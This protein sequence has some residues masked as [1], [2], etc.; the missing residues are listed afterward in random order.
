M[1]AELVLAIP[2]LLLLILLIAQFAIWAHATHIAQAA[3]S[4]ALSAARVQGGSSADGQAEADD[5]L[6]QLGSGPLR[7][8]RA[9]VNRGP[10]ESTVDI[11]GE[12][13][14][15]VPFLHL[16]VKARAVGP[17]ERFVPPALGFA[18]PE[19]PADGNP[20][21]GGKGWH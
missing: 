6:A 5:V 13:A 7:N 3:A 16:P 20:T 11:G 19:A 17:S 2:A 15:V 1:S 21:T 8:P 4:Q 18:N 9:T 12:A 10:Q 14:S